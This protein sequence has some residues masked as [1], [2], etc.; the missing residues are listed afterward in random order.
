MGVGL[1]A[2]Q[3]EYYNGYVTVDI[4]VLHM[5]LDFLVNA[6]AMAYKHETIFPFLRLP[7]SG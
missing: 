6:S 5:F 2:G 4:N 3:G 7:H 1:S